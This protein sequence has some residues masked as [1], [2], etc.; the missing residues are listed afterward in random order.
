MTEKTC[1]FKFI[2]P[3]FSVSLIVLLTTVSV[4]LLSFYNF[5]FW[6]HL[7]A[8]YP[9][10]SGSSS[11]PFIIGM[12]LLLFSAYVFLLL[13]LSFKYILR[14]AL[15]FVFVVA[16]FSS[17]AMD[18]FGYV[19][20]TQA[21]ENLS[22]TDSHEV[23]DLLSAKLGLYIFGLLIIPAMF[24]LLAKIRYPSFKNRIVYV[25]IAVLLIMGNIAVFKKSYVS[26]LRNHKQVRY[27]LN[28]VRPVYSLVKYVYQQVHE[29]VEQPFNILD[30]DP[31]LAQ[32]NGKPR[33]VVLVVGESDRAINQELN[34][35]A[36]KTNPLLS[37]RDDVY[38]FSQVFSCGTETSVSVP[39]MFSPFLREDY[40][41]AKGR[42]TENVLDLLQKS[43]VD[44]LWRDN[45]SGCKGVCERITTHDFNQ[46][47][48]DPYCNSFE[49]HDEVLLHQLQD[50]ID[51]KPGDKLIILHK[52]GNHGP[53]YYK[54]YPKQ[55]EVFTPTC[56]SNELQDCTD[57][58]I[59]NT[60][61]NIILYTDYFID[62][63]IKQ[64]EK[65]SAHYQ[66]AM[67]YVSDHGESL[68]EKGIYLHAMPYWLAP[69]EQTHVPFF[70]W[71]SQDFGIDKRMLA[72][73]QHKSFSHDNLF[74][75]LL[76]LY[77]VQ[78]KVYVQ[79]LDMFNN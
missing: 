70:F 44:V 11:L 35:Y 50:Y 2:V 1:S 51:Q 75:T 68:G 8:A 36:R 41:F 17:Y 38:S 63:V 46:A 49:C 32:H 45:D 33:L 22:A 10:S 40:T 7:L 62:L 28:P 61:D 19:I 77:K 64:L 6:R 9:L 47:K 16:A 43:Q 18:T 55:F 3:K 20:S 76:G 72:E 73:I 14:P 4:A 78:S 39:C 5:T 27:Y 15:L 56:K 66:T 59:V 29:N 67:I 30:D 74:H 53:A 37:A 34:G 23:Y 21:F 58:E 26:F 31:I 60:Y 48:I 71:S 13:L 24:V 52:L 54:R 12:A 25:L 42:Y 57:Q 79:E 65:N 69:K